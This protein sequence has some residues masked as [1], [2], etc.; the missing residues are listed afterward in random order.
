MFSKNPLLVSLHKDKM[1]IVADGVFKEMPAFDL[2]LIVPTQKG[3]ETL[4]EEW[5]F[6]G[7]NKYNPDSDNPD[8]GGCKVN[9][10]MAATSLSVPHERWTNTYG[11]YLPFSYSEYMYVTKTEDL[12]KFPQT[13]SLK[14]MYFDIEVCSDGTGIFPKAERNPIAMIGL[15]TNQPN[16][17]TI[18]LDN[19]NNT[20]GLEDEQILKD[21]LAF[22]KEY[23]PDVIVSYNGWSFDIPYILQRIKSTGLETHDLLGI[24]KSLIALSKN[25]KSYFTYTSEPFNDVNLGNLGKRIHYDIFAVDV[26]RDQKLTS[27]KNKKMKTLGKHFFKEDAEEI[28]EL[29]DNIEN[30]WAMMNNPEQK[31]LLAKYLRSDIM[32]TEKLCNIYFEANNVNLAERLNVPLSAIV[33]RRNGT[34]PTLYL[35]KKMFQNNMLPV[36]TNSVTFNYLIRRAE[37]QKKQTK[38]FQGAYVDL[39]KRGKFP[40][41]LYKTDFVGLYPSIIRTFNL[42]YETV[43]ASFELIDEPNDSI[44]N[45]TFERTGDILKISYDDCVLFARITVS[46]DMSKRG[47]VPLMLDEI[48]SERKKVKAEMKTVDSAT[49]E[50]KKLDSLQNFW[51][52][53]A[54]STYGILSQKAG[55]G[56]LPLGT[57]ITAL[58]RWMTKKVIVSL[59]EPHSE[60]LLYNTHEHMW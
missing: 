32:L 42:S 13:Q 34:L 58:G 15:K 26:I 31:A 53:L 37:T 59:N 41:K 23:D 12:Q 19:F 43:T 54:N 17:E 52:I 30:I 56:Y 3:D 14:L 44:D 24:D 7:A 11:R 1:F 47:L 4:P 36:N 29:E 60:L 40:N 10:Y 39:Y 18:I 35:M 46:I 9:D 16:A 8:F 33:N 28:V 51:K 55:I 5:F 50:Y 25:V 27:L 49:I 2:D 22:V 45:Y 48:N 21:F 38:L 20:P 6:I 57:T